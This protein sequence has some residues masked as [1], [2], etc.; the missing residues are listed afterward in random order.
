MHSY[1]KI[2]PAIGL[3]DNEKRQPK[4]PFCMK[5]GRFYSAAGF[6]LRP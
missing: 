6:G 3:S 1:S 4:L 2:R 5:P